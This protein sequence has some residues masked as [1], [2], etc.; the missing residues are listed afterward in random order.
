[1]A[2]EQGGVPSVAV[3]TDVFARLA[4]ST[5][6]ANGM[7]TTRQAYVPQPVVDRTPAQLRG[8]IEGTDPVN[9]RP[10]MQ[11]VIEGLTGP[12]TDAD[13]KGLT[14]DRSSPR[15]LPAD[16]E[17]NLQQFFMDSNWTDFLPVVLPTEARVAAMLKGTSHAPDKVVGRLSPTAFREAWEFTVEKVAVNAVM[18]G[19]RPEYFP[20]ILAMMA[21]G[22]TARSSS[23]TSFSGLAVVNGPIRNEIKMNCGIGAM[24]PFNHA[25]Q[26][27][28][29][30][31]NLASQNLQGGSTP[32]DTYMGTLGNWYSVGAAFAENEER[33][34]WAPLHTR[35][36]FKPTDSAVTVFRGGRY[37]HSGFGPREH[38]EEKMRRVFA[39][40][41]ARQSPLIV[42]D[43]I[44]A[45]LYSERGFTKESLI[46]W[47]ADNARLPASEYWN[48]QW[49]QTLIRPFAVAGVEPYASYLKAPPDEMLKLYDP[50]EINIV[51]TGGET[52][53]AW[54]IYEG[55]RM[56]DCTVSIDAWR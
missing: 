28:G 1:M 45:R 20:V 31:W 10:F 55:A 3:H 50:E 48:E 46:Q 18:A 39:A 37:T 53:G 5:A 30:A 56:K 16:T 44:V 29:R 25:N 41:E 8:Y 40:G 22:L 33:S 24:G 4:K 27:I 23:T 11:E 7:P 26:T 19:A 52:Q 2:L 13:V 43:P 17:E 15:L 51:V 54:K 49:V 42:M 34:P 38:W 14:F 35:Y 47:C 36:G 12:L 6:R 21:S 32:G 9:K